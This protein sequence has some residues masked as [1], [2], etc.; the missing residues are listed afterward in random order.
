MSSKKP[1]G[2][3]KYVYRIRGTDGKWKNLGDEVPKVDLPNYV[4]APCIPE[5]GGVRISYFIMN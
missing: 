4:W 1:I 3:R 5:S 2:G